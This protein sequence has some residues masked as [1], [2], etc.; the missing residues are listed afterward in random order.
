MFIAI[1]HKL[2]ATR[3]IFSE[4]TSIQYQIILKAQH[5]RSEYY[6]FIRFFD[7]G[8]RLFTTWPSSDLEPQP[9]RRDIIQEGILLPSH[10]SVN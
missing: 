4:N 7:I 1:N 5:I 3:S 10:A 8:E 9:E 6:H 2:S